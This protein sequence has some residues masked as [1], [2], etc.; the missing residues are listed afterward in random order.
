MADDSNTGREPATQRI[1]IEQNR[2]RRWPIAVLWALLVVSVV[3]NLALY[4]SYEDYF[5]AGGDV[6]EKYHSLAR[7]GEAKVAILSVQGPILFGEDSHVD[8]Q[9]DRIRRDD[10]VRAVVLRVDGRTVLVLAL[11][12]ILES[13]YRSAL[14]EGDTP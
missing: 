12:N 5:T 6:T 8:R 13:V 10:A 3:F 14:S 11:E 1:V 4:A 9:I 2:R 7:Q